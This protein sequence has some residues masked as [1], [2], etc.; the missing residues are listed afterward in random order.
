MKNI[1]V[2]AWFLLTILFLAS[3]FTGYFNALSLVVFSLS[4]LALVY[5]LAI[6]S[7]YVNTPEVTTK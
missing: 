3:V 2:A 6:W 4:A 1:Y 5:A 7:L